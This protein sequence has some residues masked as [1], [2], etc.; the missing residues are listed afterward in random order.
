MQGLVGRDSGQ[1]AGR[2]QSRPVRDSASGTVRYAIVYLRAVN[3]FGGERRRPSR[4]HRGTMP[5]AGAPGA[6]GDFSATLISDDEFSEFSAV[7]DRTGG[8]LPA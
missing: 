5:F 2:G 4:V 8:G 6:P 7:V 1:R 3:E